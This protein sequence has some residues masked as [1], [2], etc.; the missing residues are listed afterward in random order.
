MQNIIDTW[1]G[2]DFRRRVTVVLA[3]LAMITAVWWVG[4]TAS[5]PRMAL[6]YAGLEGG[7]AGEVVEAL[8][9]Q[10]VVFEVRGPSIYVD[11]TRRDELR[12]R[13]AGQGLPAAGGAGYELL[14]NLSGFGTTAQMFDAA[15]LRAKEGELARTISASPQIRAARVHISRP[16]LQSFRRDMI[17][18]ASVFVTPINGALSAAQGNALRYLVASAVTGLSPDNV[19]VINA[20]TGIALGD[21]EDDSAI[22][23]GDRK[24]EELRQKV[25]RLLAAHVGT[26]R[27]FV[28]V[29]VETET[30]RES[31]VERI[32]D[33]ESRVAISTE[34]EERSA[35]STDSAGAN[36]VT[37]AS[38]LPDGD[39]AADGGTS[40]SRDSR[41]RELVNYEVSETQRELLRVP[42]EIR[43]VTVAVLVDGITEIDA[44]GAEVW[45]PRTEEELAA[46]EQLVAS[47]VGFDADRGDLIT[48]KSLELQPLEA[49]GDVA[50]PGLLSRL[51]IDPVQVLQFAVFAVVALVLGLFV[52]R[53]ILSQ[54]AA[55]PA[56]SRDLPP[57]EPQRQDAAPALGDAVSGPVLT[58]EID[59]GDFPPPELE[60]L[61]DLALGIGEVDGDGLAEL[62]P[63][64]FVDPDPVARLRGM[65]EERQGETI[66]ILK[67][68]MDK[69]KA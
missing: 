15:Y 45:R 17:A 61:S 54:P 8:E 31:I 29:S 12:M 23:S 55:L 2:L 36:A 64:G 51:A 58:G 57:P 62:P 11:A 28:E 56:P 67:S 46:L 13:L 3:T 10:D 21:A 59:D 20:E 52:V 24:A 26:G 22:T 43:R 25:A 66:E 33:P 6:L 44:S 69:E 35:N 37:V 9:G 5:A 19:S 34:T 7:A 63:M 4:Q 40:S 50:A 16:N 68:W 39:A 32:F 27:T 53:P 1:S 18:S 38:N 47:A 49:V 14:D 65:I 48:I 30:R 42:G 60:A 41:T